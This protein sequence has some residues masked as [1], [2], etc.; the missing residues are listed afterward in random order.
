MTTHITSTNTMPMIGSTSWIWKAK[1]YSTTATAA[2]TPE[3]TSQREDAPYRS[4]LDLIRQL[5]ALSGKLTSGLDPVDLADQSLAAISEEIMVRRAV[6]VVRSAA[7]DF[8]P[9]RFSLTGA[10]LTCGYSEGLPVCPEHTAP[11][12]FTGTIHR[13]VIDVDGEPHVDPDAEAQAGITT[14]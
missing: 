8:T 4:A 5:Q 10:G 12:R 9:L 14:Q 1:Q 13:V 7:G 3:G 2:S 11:F 6:V